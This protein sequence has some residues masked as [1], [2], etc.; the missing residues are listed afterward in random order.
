MTHKQTH[1][2]IAKAVNAFLATYEVDKVEPGFRT[3]EEWAPI[4]KVKPRQC[5][6]HLDRLM[7]VGHAERKTFRVK[8]HT[9][10]RP[11][12]HYRISPKAVTALRLPIKD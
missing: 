12:P 3:L 10:I 6:N 8:A 5:F 11:V 2:D 4:L 1:T 7:K 9:I